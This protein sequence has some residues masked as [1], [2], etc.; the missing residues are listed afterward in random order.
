MDEEGNEKNSG[1]GIPNG[2]IKP[3]GDVADADGAQAK[4]DGKILIKTKVEDGGSG[5]GQSETTG[6]DA[7]DT[8]LRYSND[9][10][11]MMHL[12]GLDEDDPEAANEDNTGWQ[13][14]TGFQG[15]RNLRDGVNT[16]TRNSRLSNELHVSAF[17]NML[18]G[19]NEE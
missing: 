7:E 3:E 5:A 9:N 8:F 6:T 15:R 11:R 18:F 1:F 17:V 4:D 19:E 16:N 2:N 10:V 12:L 13:Q 14:L